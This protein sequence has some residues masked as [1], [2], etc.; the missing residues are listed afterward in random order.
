MFAN[1]YFKFK[2]ETKTVFDSHSIEQ[3]GQFINY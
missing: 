3:E 1:K 2:A